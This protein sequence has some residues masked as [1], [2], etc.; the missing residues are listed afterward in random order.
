[1]LNI[2]GSS[3]NTSLKL[4]INTLS[5]VD[6]PSYSSKITQKL[7]SFNPKLY[8]ILKSQSSSCETSNKRPNQFLTEDCEMTKKQK[9]EARNINM[10][11]SP[12]ALDKSF[13]KEEFVEERTPFLEA[14]YKTIHSSNPI[15]L[16]PTLPSNHSNLLRRKVIYPTYFQRNKPPISQHKLFHHGG[17][18]TINLPPN[19]YHLRTKFKHLP[20]IKSYE[21]PNFSYSINNSNPSPDMHALGLYRQLLQLELA[22]LGVNPKTLT[23]RYQD[24]HY[25]HKLREESF[26]FNE[27]KIDPPKKNRVPHSKINKVPNIEKITKKI[28]Q[29]TIK[30]TEES[31]IPVQNGCVTLGLMYTSFQS[32]KIF[33]EETKNFMKQ[34]LKVI[35][36][37]PTNDLNRIFTPSSQFKINFTHKKLEIDSTIL[38]ITNKNDSI[39]DNVK[40]EVSTDKS[41]FKHA[42]HLDLPYE[43]AQSSRTTDVSMEMISDSS[44]PETPFEQ[45][46]ENKYADVPIFS[47]DKVKTEKRRSPKLNWCPEIAKPE[48]LDL[49]FKTLKEAIGESIDLNEERTLKVLKQCD[50]EQE[51]ITEKISQNKMFYKYYLNSDQRILRNKI[52]Y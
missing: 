8:N 31:E 23:S 48:V 37:K 27:L 2:Y 50:F 28:E 22:L 4:N 33:K 21:D 3:N 52:S 38:P 26:V 36:I 5:N 6:Q 42:N 13:I 44:K 35:E 43:R 12:Q 19:H 17:K 47:F 30:K 39:L 25:S 7:D 45:N 24:L 20:L 49:G 51:K 1:M 46:N 41:I 14:K 34:P 11:V 29:E 15:C 18:G 40:I 9:I 32:S 10:L 16:K